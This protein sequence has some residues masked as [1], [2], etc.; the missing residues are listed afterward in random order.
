MCYRY[1]IQ[2][3]TQAAFTLHV[4]VDSR[5]NATA[6]TCAISVFQSLI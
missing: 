2:S 4:H 1:Y 5:A 6:A 3:Y